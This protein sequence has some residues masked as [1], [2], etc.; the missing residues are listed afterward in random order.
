MNPVIKKQI[1]ERW[2]WC[3]NY[4]EQHRLPPANPHFWREANEEYDKKI[5][6]VEGEL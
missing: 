1:E 5:A 3:M 4:C 2:S 6:K